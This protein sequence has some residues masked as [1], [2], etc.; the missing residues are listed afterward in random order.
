MF[1]NKRDCNPKVCNL[2]VLEV[3]EASSEQSKDQKD[4]QN[5]YIVNSE[6]LK[7]FCKYWYPQLSDHEELR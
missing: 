1:V 6:G 2:E 4:D 5:S 3:M 7:I